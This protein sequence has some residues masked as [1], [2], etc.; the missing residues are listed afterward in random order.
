MSTR[1][2]Y[3]Q[4]IENE[5]QFRDN[6]ASP[7][8]VHMKVSDLMSEYITA[9][10]F[11]LNV[12]DY[13]AIG[14]GIADDTSSILRAM[15]DSFNIKIPSGTY[16]ITSTITVVSGETIRIVGD[17]K[18][19][20]SVN[21]AA[22]GNFIRSSRA[23]TFENIIF[24]FNNS[25][26]RSGILF[27]PDCGEITFKNCTF[28][29]IKDID[30]SYATI[31]L[32][33]NVQGNTF[34]LDGLR[35]EN[36]LKR[37]NNTIT[38]SAGSLDCIYIGAAGDYTSGSIRNCFFSEIH[39]I[40]ASD[41]I[42][43]E[44]VACI[45]IITSANDTQNQ[46]DIDG[47]YGYNFG[48]RLL[49]IQAANVTVSNVTGY[50]PEGDSLGVIG[51][52]G[53]DVLGEKRGC[54]GSHIRAYGKM[55]SALSGSAVGIKWHD[56]I[57]STTP[58]TKTGM[59]NGS[60]GLLINGNYTEINGYRST[61]TYMIGIGS[62]SQVII[63]TKLKNITL[64]LDS[65]TIQGFG[66]IN[67][68]IGFDGLDID[69]MTINYDGT[70]TAIPIVFQ[71]LNGTTIKGKNFLAKNIIIISNGL[72][73]SYGF[74]AKYTDNVSLSNYRYRN[75]SVNKHFRLAIFDTCLNVTVDDVVIEGSAAIGVQLVNCTGRGLVNNVIATSC[76]FGVYNNNSGEVTVSN[77]DPS[78]VSGNV[79]TLLN[80]RYST[81]ITSSRPVS[82]LVVGQQHYDT[83][84]SKPVWWTGS[85]W[86]DAAGNTV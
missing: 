42:I 78:K 82:N 76:D 47:I 10:A 60:F 54:S 45:Y 62:S 85:V 44:D 55:E 26:L 27:D 65:T 71:Y 35:F 72:I 61:S 48:K 74:Y 14:N 79:V 22:S 40:N 49:K 86:K 38:D 29:N 9:S 75:T 3:F 6:P 2:N 83:T 24:D 19:I 15:N 43:Y 7:S 53:G 77:T 17:S 1:N 13:G 16:K 70:A 57:T 28:R 30:S 80:Q 41:Q 21:L 4:L 34:D 73:N 69:G 50:S 46:I 56:V 11:M 12:K 52:L 8:L 36:I 58:G 33:I 37:G 64:D 5:N 25:Y 81:G 59:S 31:P 32:Y 18:T 67:G 23:L 68:N 39:N 63:G 84:L 20:L 51:F 66:D